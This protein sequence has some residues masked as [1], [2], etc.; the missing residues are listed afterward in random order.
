MDGGNKF[1]EVIRESSEE[2]EGSSEG[3]GGEPGCYF[4]HGG[5]MLFINVKHRVQYGKA[6]YVTGSMPMLGNWCPNKAIRLTWSESHNWIANISLRSSKKQLN[7]KY[8]YFESDYEMDSESSLEWEPGSNR[9]LITDLESKIIISVDDM[10]SLVK[11]TF[12]FALN[13]SIHSVFIAGEQFK[14]GY[15]ESNPAKMSLRVVRDHESAGIMHF[16]EKELFIP[17]EIDKIEYNYGIKER[18]NSVI[19]WE[20][21]SNRVFNFKDIRYYVD[22]QFDMFRD[23][24][25]IHSSSTSFTF[26]ASCYIRMDHSFIDDFIYSEITD[27]LWVGPYPKY[28][29][30]EK[31]KL[32]GS[33]CIINLQTKLEMEGLLMSLDRY[34]EICQKQG[35]KYFHSPITQNGELSSQEVL[36]AVN[37]LN[38]CIISY[39]CV[40]LHC[41]NGS[42]RCVAVAIIYFHIIRGYP[43][44][45]SFEIVMAKRWRAKVSE[46]SIASL[47]KEIK[48]SYRTSSNDR[49]LSRTDSL[50]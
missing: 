6:V 13:E 49:Q 2:D 9:T 4:D 17:C 28:E 5:I 23:T 43:V 34:E 22:E 30:I 39:K 18:K 10:W 38:N 11:I 36:E 42:K 37:L 29:E 20:R 14:L 12:R 26:K 3:E 32:K 31:L 50:N 15:S 8:K 47:I 7:L 44:K 24:L 45:Q 1:R 21:D 25:G 27:F 46:T 40:Y 33:K 35:I 19:R 48:P 41:T 16:W